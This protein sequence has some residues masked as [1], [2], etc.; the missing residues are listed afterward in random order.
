MPKTTYKPRASMCKMPTVSSITMSGAHTDGYVPYL[1]HINAMLNTQEP[2]N[3]RWFG[4]A[5]AGKCLNELIKH[6][7]RVQVAY[8][9]KF[10][11]F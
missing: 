6:G 2:S 11:S 7:L 9:I 4:M 10:K 5:G 1:Y 8:G 3:S